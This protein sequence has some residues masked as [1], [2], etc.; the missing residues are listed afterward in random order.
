[1]EYG[2]THLLGRVRT[3]Q[4]REFEASITLSAG[5]AHFPEDSPDPFERADECLYE[6][7][8]QGRDCWHL[9]SPETSSCGGM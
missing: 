6:S 8:R 1:V 4:W 2:L 3:L 9:S 7:K 5:G